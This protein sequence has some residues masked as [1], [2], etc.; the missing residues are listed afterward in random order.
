MNLDELKRLAG[1]TQRQ[2]ITPASK[3]VFD[4]RFKNDPFKNFPVNEFNFPVGF[5]GRKKK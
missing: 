2:A 1:I 3:E 5:R 4:N